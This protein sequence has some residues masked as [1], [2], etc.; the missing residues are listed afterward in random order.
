[1]KSYLSEIG[2]Y[3]ETVS[4]VIG[5]IGLFLLG[6]ILMTDGM[7]A[8]AGDSLKDRLSRLTGGVSRSILSGAAVTAIVQSSSA[9]TLMTIGFVSA[10]LIS[11]TQ[12][13]GVILG[14]NL[15]STSTGWIVSVIGLKFSVTSFALP[16]IGIGALMRFFTNGKYSTQGIVIAG[17]GLLFLGIGTLQDGMSSLTTNFSLEQYAGDSILQLLILVIVG[18]VMTIVLQSSSTAMVI[19]LTALAADALSFE[20]A[21][22]LVIGQNIGTTA[23]AYLA[24]LGGTVQARRTAMTHISFN[25]TVAIIAFVTLPLILSFIEWLE[26]MIK[27]DVAISLALFSTLIYVLGIIVIVPFLPL[28]IK[29]INK[30]VPEKGD[31]LTKYL[32]AS[33]ATVPAVA[34]EAV[35]RTLIRISK[36]ICSVGTELFNQKN[37]TPLMKNQLLEAEAALN[38]TR[39]FLT[40]VGSQSLSTKENEYTMQIALI[41]TIDHLDRLMKALCESDY[42][43]QL[44]KDHIL[45]LSN[46]ME[47]L[48]LEVF[49]QQS[50]DRQKILLLKVKT[51]SL[52][53]A[54]I[55]RTSRKEIIEKT[56]LHPADID[57]TIQKVHTLHWIDRIAYH[58]W[59]S[60][61]HLDKCQSS[62]KEESEA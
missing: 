42:L 54:E 56:V 21:T 30:M 49:E 8:L 37:L 11:F 28:Y 36:A 62:T 15:G 61:H 23:K 50:Y 53:I 13:I 19:T 6:M 1:M 27:F 51:N 55:R 38:E 22:V 18:I 59:R 39:Q 24:T 4:V 41:H 52:A 46:E 33:V 34:I 14:A 35:R 31:K 9:T 7:K 12:S 20:H 10:G 17:F 58:L 60:L 57:T 25:I 43:D 2:D 44:H 45:A 16:L 29:M 5:G 47:E 32:D 48:F 3:L 26:K 40:Q